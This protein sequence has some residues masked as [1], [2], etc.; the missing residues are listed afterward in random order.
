MR[1]SLA[2]ILGRAIPLAIVLALVMAALPLTPVSAA[3]NLVRNPG[4][5]DP[6][7]DGTQ[8]PTYWTA[9]TTSPY[10]DE[11]PDVH[12]GSYSAYL[13]G[14]SGSY[15]QT[16]TIGGNATYTFEAYA[17]ANASATETVSVKIRD[18]SAAILDER[19][20]SGSNHG[21]T[22]RLAVIVT[23]EK[24]W[25]ALI[26][27][28]ISGDSAA[29][30]WFDDIAFEQKGCF[31]AT[32]AYGSYLDRHVET[33]RS[34]RDSYMLTNP[35]GSGLVSAY[36]TLSPPVAQFVDDHPGLKPIA[37]IALLPAVALSSAAVQTTCVQKMATAGS[38]FLVCAAAV[39]W[40]TRRFMTVPATHS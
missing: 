9:S 38:L 6:A 26:T 39:A 35:L 37:R 20:W 16:V 1:R 24:A 27:L 3:N 31:V 32:S 5:E 17:R 28:S 4:F 7:G 8:P 30:A 15:T 29:E 10:R 36:Y 13:H 40:L 11:P 34:F 19:S 25:D 18:S 21:W 22:K 14:S 23:P 2:P 12:L 33:L